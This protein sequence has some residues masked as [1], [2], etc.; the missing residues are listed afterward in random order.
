VASPFAYL[1]QISNG[2]QGGGPGPCGVGP[3]LAVINQIVSRLEEISPEI[4]LN[5]VEAAMSSLPLH[6]K[7]SG[8]ADN[9][10]L[11]L[12]VD[13]GDHH[14]VKMCTRADLPTGFSDPT[15]GSTAYP[16]GLQPNNLGQ[17]YCV[18][19][20]PL[21]GWVVDTQFT[22]SGT[23]KG[24]AHY[25]DQPFTQPTTNFAGPSYST[26]W[27]WG[28]LSSDT[29]GTQPISGQDMAMFTPSCGASN[30]L[31]ELI[32]LENAQGTTFCKPN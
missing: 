12:Y 6:L 31:G 30:I 22:L 8:T 28:S 3:G 16:D 1:T 13:P 20:Y 18:E 5:Q 24:D 7:N 2:T 14:T 17:G 9:G 10:T 23:G 4:D 27:W 26:D 21:N 25:H 15:Y 29:G 11:Y 19:T 32:F